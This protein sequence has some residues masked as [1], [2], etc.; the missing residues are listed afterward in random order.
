MRVRYIEP[1][2]KG[3]AVEVI[4]TKE[5]ILNNYF[6]VWSERMKKIGKEHLISYDNCIEDFITVHWAER[7]NE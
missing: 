1:D 3:K 7:E 5:E 6:P 2:E 4:V